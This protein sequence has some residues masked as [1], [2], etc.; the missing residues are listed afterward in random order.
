MNIQKPKPSGTACPNCGVDKAV[1]CFCASVDEI[2][3]QIKCVTCQDTGLVDCETDEG[4]AYA[5]NCSSCDG[6]GVTGK[7]EAVAPKPPPG[8]ECSAVN[9]SVR[10]VAVNCARKPTD[11]R[12]AGGGV[13]TIRHRK[14]PNVTLKTRDFSQTKSGQRA[15]LPP[16]R[17]SKWAAPASGARGPKRQRTQRRRLMTGL[18]VGSYL[19][20]ST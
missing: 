14:P 5:E 13:L 6:T 19:A 8:T 16:R 18:P 3:K 20:V 11:L 2:S 7:A 1:G 9:G 10:Y 4:E 15:F 12:K 17:P